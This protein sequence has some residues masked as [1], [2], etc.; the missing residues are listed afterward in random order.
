[1]ALEAKKIKKN[2]MYQDVVSQIEG[3]IV[4]GR[5]APGDQ[6]PPEMVLKNQLGASRGTVREAL[7]V[8]E[9][10]GL[11]EVRP[12]AT[13]GAFVQHASIDKLTDSLGLLMQLRQVSFD[14]M[15]EFRETVE[16]QATALAARR[17]KPEDIATLRDIVSRARQV[18]SES[19]D[20]WAGLC[21]TDI[22]LHVAIA[23]I[24]DNPVFLAVTRMIHQTILG[25]VDRFALRGR[26][27]LQANVDD[28]EKLVTAIE[29]GDEELAAALAWEHVADFNTHLKKN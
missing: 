6:L 10:K 18:L 12:G 26:D 24:A 29:S 4:D 16:S 8:L 27:A 19:P 3:A 20:D 25:D 15:A 14:H 7:R 21:R 5:L 11:V 23:N 9:E 22:E 2:K 13:G 28:M 17:A 1:M